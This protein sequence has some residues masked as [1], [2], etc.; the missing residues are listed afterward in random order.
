MP[1]KNKGFCIIN[2]NQ[3]EESIVLTEGFFDGLRLYESFNFSNIYCI[4]G[5]SILKSDLKHFI[6]KFSKFILCF[7]NDEAGR[8]NT[9][10]ILLDILIKNSLAEIKIVKLIEKD[11]DENFIK[12]INMEYYFSHIEF[13]KYFL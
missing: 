10:K 12:H 13:I 3:S 2:I 7:D 9:H 6:Q 5:S 1:N 4:N 11:A 8:Q